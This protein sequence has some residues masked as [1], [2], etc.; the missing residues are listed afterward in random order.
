M[1]E[2]TFKSVLYAKAGRGADNL[3]THRTQTGS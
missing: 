2:H 1:V 3:G